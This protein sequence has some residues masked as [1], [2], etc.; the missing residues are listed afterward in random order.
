MEEKHGRGVPWLRPLPLLLGCLV[1]SLC[2]AVALAQ[3]PA[4]P[5]AGP[6]GTEP[7]K[8]V[9]PPTVLSHVDA[10]YPSSA[11]KERKHADVVLALTVDVDGHVSKVDVMQSGGADL[12]EAAIVAARQWTFNPAKRGDDAVRSR[13]K[14]PFHFA[15]PELPPDVVDDSKANTLPLQP[16]VPGPSTGPAPVPGAATTPVPQ[17]AGAQDADTGDLGEVHVQGRSTPP[18]VGASDFNLHIGAL[19]NV[20]HQS[21]AELLKLAPGI[22]LTNEGGEG[23]AE[24]VFLRGF[25]AREG[26]DIEFTVG[27]VPINESGNLHGN[28]YAD[29][30]FIIPELVKQLRVVEGP[31]DPRQGNYAVAGSA[32]YELGLEKRGLTAKLT[33]G[34]FGTERM[35]VMW[36]P[37]GESEHTF[38][39]AE[40][41]KTDGFGQNRDSKRGSAY[42]QYEGQIGRKGT[43]R[44]S[45]QIYTT[46]YHSAGV[47][48][49]DD[50]QAG[51]IGFYGT[52]DPQQG[53]DS[54]RASVASDL[55]TKVGN[56]TLGQQF[57]VIKRTMRLREDFTGYLLDVQQPWQTAHGQ[58]GDLLDLNVDET[59]MGARGFARLATRAFG[60]PQQIE[61]GYFARYDRVGGMQQRVSPT[62]LD[63]YHTDTN[64][65]SNL[66]DVGLYGAADLRPV[67]WLALRGGLR[68]DVFTFDVNNLC[69]HQS[70]NTPSPQTMPPPLDASCMDQTDYGVHVEPNQ[71]ADTSSAV[72]LPKAAVIVGPFEHVTFSASYGQGV[73]SIDPAYLTQDVATPFASIAAYEGGAAYA[74]PVGPVTLV[75]RS[76]FFDTHVDKDYIFDQT[77]GRNVIGVGT[78]RVGWVGALR[79]TGDWFDESANITF[80]RSTYDDTHLLVPYVPDIVVRSDTAVWHDLPL[81]LCGAPFRGALSAGITYVGRRPL[82]FGALS[83]TIFTA[84]ANATLAWKLYEIGVTTTNL[85]D[86]KYRLSEFNY[87]SNF[88]ASGPGAPS[89]PPSYVPARL[90]TAGAPR[91]IFANFTINF[92]GA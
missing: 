55:E 72:V 67:K 58:R 81:K 11:L 85:L 17:P 45:G 68:A 88:N 38:A 53:G 35:L 46:D 74:G 64:L 23:H 33:A 52:Y 40:A 77:V 3:E 63:P 49:E 7:A 70:I 32:D 12:D 89:G 9:R 31:F 56:T 92:G 61:L 79:A 14:V 13:I 8:A 34:S 15:P 62:T 28:G 73:R 25:D 29:T 82:P 21:A 87:V 43:Y 39:A 50:Y 1:V 26:Q 24:Q 54:F 57:F 16:A 10:V 66:G 18:S 30:H 2:P 65:Q 80:V 37:N 51:R 6:A 59:T 22:L 48:R 27:G 84:D 36:G 44:V 47:I 60:L 41:Y 86:T 91:G 4:P 19:A 20:P 76:V 5:P 42:A 90:F 78:S 75:A 69:A 83:G 71:R